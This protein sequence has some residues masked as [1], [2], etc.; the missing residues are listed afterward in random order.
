MLPANYTTNVTFNLANESVRVLWS[1]EEMNISHFV[2]LT[3]SNDGFDFS[4]SPV[5]GVLPSAFAKAPS[6][7][8]DYSLVL[9]FASERRG[10]N[11]SFAVK[12][13][14]T[15]AVELPAGCAYSQQHAGNAT[16]ACVNQ[17]TPSNETVV[18]ASK[19]FN[20][21][22]LSAYAKMRL[23]AACSSADATCNT[24][25]ALLP[26]VRINTAKFLSVDVGNVFAEAAAV[27]QQR[28]LLST[29]T[30]LPVDVEVWST[31]VHASLAAAQ[32][33]SSTIL[34]T[35][36]GVN[37][38]LISSGAFFLDAAAAAGS[39]LRLAQPSWVIPSCATCGSNYTLSNL[40]SQITMP[41]LTAG[42]DGLPAYAFLV[43]Y[44]R[45]RKTAAEG[46]GPWV[47][48]AQWYSQ[49]NVRQSV[50][51]TLVGNTLSLTVENDTIGEMEVR[52]RV[53]SSSAAALLRVNLAP[54]N[55]APG[56]NVSLPPSAVVA[57]S[58]NST[59]VGASTSAAGDATSTE[60]GGRAR[61][62]SPTR[63]PSHR[64]RCR[65]CRASPSTPP[66]TPARIAARGSRCT[67]FTWASPP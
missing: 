67:R 16:A 20:V 17:S 46:Y 8:A 56:F 12:M 65:W 15:R 22:V 31:T 2:Q 23:K 4:V 44:V 7:G 27:G 21:S 49:Q 53:A 57:A 50:A 42:P 32:L 54:T 38:T 51:P 26:L 52:V 35:A 60:A 45:H 3:G 5:G 63:S 13:S 6:I 29:V 64:R 30:S 18:V 48:D 28:R 62:T 39:Y 14:F 40:V 58:E 47:S 11:F 10:G 36:L 1:S 41:N 33:F 59:D 19:T 9:P 66:A 55:L 37:V 43:E 61:A 25:G 34:S 24:Y